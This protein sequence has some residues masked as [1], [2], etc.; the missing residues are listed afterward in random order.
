MKT[1][2][3]IARTLGR[4]LT[5]LTI[6][7]LMSSPT[8]VSAQEQVKGPQK[9][10]QLNAITTAANAQAVQAGDMVAMS[11]PRCKNR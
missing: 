1:I 6:A 2:N 3:Q 11:C 9:L 5:V 4:S 7:G 10:K 8:L